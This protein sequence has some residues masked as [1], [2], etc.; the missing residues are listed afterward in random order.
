M[1]RGFRAGGSHLLG[2]GMI[3]MRRIWLL[4]IFAERALG[5]MKDHCIYL[6]STWMGLTIM[7]A[8]QRRDAP[9]VILNRKTLT[10]RSPSTSYR[11]PPPLPP[12]SSCHN[13]LDLVP[14][15][16]ALDEH[17]QGGFLLQRE[18]LQP[19]QRGVSPLIRRPI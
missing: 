1:F 17:V 10:D 7:N 13:L 3:Q 8:R 18:Y 4:Y 19:P 15:W 5:A 12:V 9:G 2:D 6:Y 16:L 11:T 14:H